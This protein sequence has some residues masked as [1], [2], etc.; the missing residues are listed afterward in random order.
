MAKKRAKRKVAK[1]KAAP[2]KPEGGVIPDGG[3]L[4]T[5]E[6]PDDLDAVGQAEF[7]RLVQ[8]LN[9]RGRLESTDLGL[10]VAY[11][12]TWSLLVRSQRWVNEHGMQVAT[13][14]DQGNVKRVS[15]APCVSILESASRRLRMLGKELGLTP[16]GRIGLELAARRLLS[17]PE[18]QRAREALADRL[19][20]FGEQ[21]LD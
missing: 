21:G 19:A 14:D 3:E 17:G 2:A 11:C 20:R 16:A 18:K 6:A 7:D 5:V 12:S 1:K 10:L 4:V 8:L 15:K 9:E 13:H